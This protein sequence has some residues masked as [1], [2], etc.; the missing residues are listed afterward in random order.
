METKTF[1]ENLKRLEEVVRSLENKDISLEEAVKNYTIGLE[2]S[3]KCYD[4]LNTNEQL[5]VQKMTE[6]GL[7]DM[8][9]D[10]E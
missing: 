9:R 1:E 2:L 10:K 3:K 8:Q 6:S 7:V 4:I 5:V